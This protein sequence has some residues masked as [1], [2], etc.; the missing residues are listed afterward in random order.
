MILAVMNVSSAITYI[1][2]CNIQDRNGVWTRDLTIP[3][4][5]SN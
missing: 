1:E 2:A 4:R 3:V 5:R